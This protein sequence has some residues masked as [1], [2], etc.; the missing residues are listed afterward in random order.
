M[1]L[2]L[3]RRSVRWSPEDQDAEVLL[4]IV[5]SVLHT[6]LDEDQAARFDRAIFAGDA[7]LPASADHVIDLV[8]PMWPLPVGRARSPD[9]QADTELLRAQKID[10][11][12]SV[13]IARLRIEVRNLVRFHGRTR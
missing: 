3:T 7:D 9:G 6:G 8:F 4:D 11:A 10:I 12:V 2:S 1:A 13:G 5:E